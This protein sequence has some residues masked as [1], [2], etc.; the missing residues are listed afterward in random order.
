MNKSYA[1]FVNKHL[2][3][4]SRSGPEWQC[5][6]PF[7]EDTTPSFSVNIRKGLYICYACQAK[8]S[9]DSL[10]SHVTGE[11]SGGYRQDT[12]TIQEVKEKIKHFRVLETGPPP[13]KLIAPEWL[14]HWRSGFGSSG[15]LYLDEWAKRGVHHQV[16]CDRFT[17][18]YD[19]MDHSLIMP[20]HNSTGNVEGVVR[21]IIKP[22]VGHPKY[23]YPRG[24]KISQT[25]YGWHQVA[26]M[27]G[28]GRVPV[29]GVTEGGIDTLLAWQAGLPSVALLGANCSPQ[30]LKLITSLDPVS[31]LV[32]TDNDTAGRT[33]GLQLAHKLSGTGVMVQLPSF[34]P[35]GRKDLGEMIESEIEQV[36]AS[37]KRMR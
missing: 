1:A 37:G 11:T 4:H 33:A 14:D 10:V 6:C 5:L 18:G 20:M 21:R 31:V 3:V 34:W 35:Q 16:I 15:P 36:I 13:V 23:R 17:L 22:E 9:F 8:G 12:T 30:Q 2:T 26:S 7:H 25:L 24:F 27:Q 32:L 19:P 28:A 29:L